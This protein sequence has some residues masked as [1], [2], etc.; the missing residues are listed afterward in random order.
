[1]H[2]LMEL[3]MGQKGSLALGSAFGRPSPLSLGGMS[4]VF[5]VLC[6]EPG[7]SLRQV[8]QWWLGRVV[9]L[10]Q[11]MARSHGLKNHS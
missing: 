10:D 5:S 2:M 1:M 6:E 4:Y 8:S 7:T 9:V 11:L 3:C